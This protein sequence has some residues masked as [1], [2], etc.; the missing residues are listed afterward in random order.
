MWDADLRSTARPVGRR[1]RCEDRPG[2]GRWSADG[3][4]RGRQCTPPAT[5]GPWRRERSAAGP[6]VQP[7]PVLHLLRVD[8]SIALGEL[9]Q[10]PGEGRRSG[11]PR[12]SHREASW[13]TTSKF[14]SCS[15]PCG[16]AASTARVPSAAQASSRRSTSERR[17]SPARSRRATAR[18]GPP[19][20]LVRQGLGR[21]SAGEHARVEPSAT[22]GQADQR[23]VRQAHRRSPEAGSEVKGVPGIG[24]KPRSAATSRTS[25]EAKMPRPRSTR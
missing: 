11:R 3:S 13:R 24:Q 23:R 17:S 1:A 15:S 21:E 19:L 12:A 9:D 20:A 4:R 25:G 16:D 5:R 6:P 10:A 7:G 18:S 2:A 14:P 8:A 22:Q